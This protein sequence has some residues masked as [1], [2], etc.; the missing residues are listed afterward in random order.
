M[1]FL[2]TPPWDS[3]NFPPY[4]AAPCFRNYPIKIKQLARTE[5][6]SSS[7]DFLRTTLSA[8][9][10][11]RPK[12]KKIWLH[13]FQ[14]HET[15]YS[16]NPRVCLAPC[17]AKPN[18]LIA[19]VSNTQ[20]TPWGGGTKSL[21]P[22]S[23]VRKNLRVSQIFCLFPSVPQSIRQYPDRSHLPSSS[24]FR[25]QCLLWSLKGQSPGAHPDSVPMARPPAPAGAM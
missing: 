24:D 10:G 2:P 7:S 17:A 6:H 23:K 16:K 25:F 14:T 15:H 20:D 22:S 1:S 21:T 18:K 5:M 11:F 4:E 12:L 9:W 8:S 19:F 13:S 3:F